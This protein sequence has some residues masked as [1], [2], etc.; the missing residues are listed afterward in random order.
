MNIGTLLIQPQVVHRRLASED[1]HLADLIAEFA[2]PFAE[3][4]SEKGSVRTCVVQAFQ[5]FWTKHKTHFESLWQQN[6]AQF[7]PLIQPY[8][9]KS[10]FFKSLSWDFDSLRK[11]LEGVP[12]L[13]NDLQPA[14]FGQ[15][16]EASTWFTKAA[17]KGLA[18]GGANVMRQYIPAARTQELAK[19]IATA[20][21]EALKSE[22]KGVITSLGKANIAIGA[23]I[24]MAKMPVTAQ[25]GTFKVVGCRHTIRKNTGFI[26]QF[27]C[28]KS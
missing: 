3:H 28:I 19:Q 25:N 9:G 21:W 4:L 20:L 8:I 22:K 23:T 14:S 13:V 26:T 2:I 10:A 17:V 12:Q 7:M 1:V 18:G 27:E 11:L 6:K 15:G 16:T 5:A 24:E